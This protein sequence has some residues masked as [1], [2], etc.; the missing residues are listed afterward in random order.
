MLRGQQKCNCISYVMKK[1]I[2]SIKGDNFAGT[3][4]SKLFFNNF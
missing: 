3:S 4:L 1:T 2:K